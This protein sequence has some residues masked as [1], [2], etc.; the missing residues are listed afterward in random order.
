[1][2]WH[3]FMDKSCQELTIDVAELS[4]IL[5]EPVSKVKEVNRDSDQAITVPIDHRSK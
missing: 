5:C 4:L 3:L 1:M 2:K